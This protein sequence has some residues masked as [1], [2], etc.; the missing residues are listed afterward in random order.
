MEQKELV[1][2]KGFL[3]GLL[4]IELYKIMRFEKKEFALSKHIL[5]KGL[6]IGF[7]L[8]KGVGEPVRGDFLSRLSLALEMAEDTH[9]WL[10]L[11]KESEYL[12][13]DLIGFALSECDDICNLV[14]MM[15]NQS[16]NVGSLFAYNLIEN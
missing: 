16:N 14:T 11:I 8:E 6:F 12:E 10:R 9:Y 2:Q 7:Y 15:L 5:D 3:F 4:M 13:D 1:R